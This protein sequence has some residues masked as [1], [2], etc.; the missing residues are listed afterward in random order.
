MTAILGI[1]R[2]HKGV[3]I[4]SKIGEGATFSILFSI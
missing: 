4:E 1:V 2:G 3:I